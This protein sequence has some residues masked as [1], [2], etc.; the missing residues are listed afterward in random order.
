[1]GFGLSDF[2]QTKRAILERVG[3]LEVVSQHVAMKQRGQRWV[4]L[5]PF[6][7][8]KT[9]SFTIRPEH[10]TFKCFG[11]GRG[12][13]VFTF[14][15]L[16]ENVGFVE[17]MR[18]LADRA[19]I[20]LGKLSARTG[21]NSGGRA[22][23]AKLNAWAASAFHNQLQHNARGAGAREYLI[24]RKVSPESSDRFELGISIDHAADLRRLALQAGFDVALL[25]EADLLRR[26]DDNDVY[27]T[28]RH[29]LMFPIHDATARIVG[30]GGRTLGDDPA[31]YLNTRQN[32]LF[33]KGRGLYG[34]D[35]ARES[36]VS[37]RRAIVVEGYLDCIAAHQA[38]FAETVATLGTALTES[39]VELLRRHTEEVI[40]L[41][42]SDQAGQAAA[43]RAIQVAL[44]KGISVRLARIPNGKDPADFLEL[45]TPDEFSDVLN[46][47]IGALEFKWSKVQEEFSSL[48]T[49]GRR[50]EA[51]LDFIRFIA[52]ATDFGAIDPIHR[53]FMV[54]H[55]AHVVQIDRTE[56]DRLFKQARPRPRGVHVARPAA[57]LPGNSVEA[58]R[59]REQ[60]AWTRLLEAALN[61]PGLLLDCR[62]LPDVHRIADER[63]RR[64]F[65]SVIELSNSTGEFELG[66]V[67]AR[68]QA[69][70]DVDRVME[71]ARLGAERGNLKRSFETALERL[72]RV[73]SDDGC[74]A[75]NRGPSG[76]GDVPLDAAGIAG[77][78]ESASRR[79]REHRGYVPRRMIRLATHEAI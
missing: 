2:V 10:G 9:P 39:Q 77:E 13:D 50:R 71:L 69:P 54:N 30:F 20:D 18:I 15:Q 51:A 73:V 31:K 8:E 37:R 66:D 49:V 40:L 34:I 48:D 47:A 46:G 75:E 16:R 38:G 25:L 60:S 33:D 24:R 63:D 55:I 27:S 3:L 17:A 23:L 21:T 56:A 19:G 44:P 59:G 11:C 42:D 76:D 68:F 7:A 70:E 12:G 78:L 26:N 52:Q 29:R 14:V 6:H 5:C 28:F 72:R 79:A 57:N 62:Q 43:D 41:F 45:A 4:G 32:E 64:I 58:G 65:Q 36:I 35:R 67:L 74:T 61:E 53:G 1:M 22:Q